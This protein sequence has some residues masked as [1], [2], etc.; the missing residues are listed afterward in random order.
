MT[1]PLRLPCP[2]KLNLFLHITGRRPDGYHELQTVFQLLDHVDCLTLRLREDTQCTF[3]TD[4]AELAQLDPEKN[5]IVRAARLLQRETGTRLGCD[6]FLEK[7]L[8]MG[9]GVGGGSSDAATALLG[10]NQLW[11]LGLTTAELAKL[12]LA[13]GADVPVFVEGHSAFAEGVGEALQPVDLP[14]LVF[15]VLQPECFI[16]TADLFSQDQLTRNTPKTTFAAYRKDLS[17]LVITGVDSGLFHNDCE[18]VARALF[19]PVDAALQFLERQ[20]QHLGKGMVRM[21]GTGAC[22]FLALP[23]DVGQSDLVVQQLSGLLQQAPC[24]GF[25]CRGV[26]GSPVMT[27]MRA[28]QALSS[29]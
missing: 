8:P 6:F 16:S 18:P 15:L 24:S 25:V 22:V 23:A 1:S 19:P 10:L 4:S 11:H 7:V 3:A 29:P 12:G 2:A 27:A 14:S 21:T 13:L 9:G 17:Q 28:M 5:L 26:S 20:R